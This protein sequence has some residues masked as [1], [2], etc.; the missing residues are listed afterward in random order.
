VCDNRVTIRQDRLE[1]Q[2]LAALEQRL[3]NAQLI[4]YTVTRFHQA[5]EKRIAEIQRQSTGA[6]E[7]RRQRRE[8]TD[9]R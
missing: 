8:F 1:E 5:L 7:L 6:D 2:L 9:P 4:D 3:S